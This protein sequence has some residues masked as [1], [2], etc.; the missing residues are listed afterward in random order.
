MRSFRAA[1]VAFVAAAAVAVVAAPLAT[2]DAAGLT[3]PVIDVH[4][5]INKGVSLSPNGDRSKDRASIKFTLAKKS[6]VIVRV[7][8]HNRARTVVYKK[9]LGTLSRGDHTWEW[10]GKNLNGNVVRDG[11]YSAVF[12]A[13]Q[14]AQ[15]GK[16]GRRSAGVF[17]DTDFN[18]Q[19][20]PKLS[21]DIVYP[22]TTV[23]H[24]EIGVTLDND[25]YDPMTAL[26]NVVSTLK[27]AQG[28]VVW[29][30]RPF[31]Y[32]ASE[33]PAVM[34]LS[35][36]GLDPKNQHP[37]PAGTYRLRYKVWDMAGNR[38]GSK[39]VTVHVSG[40]PLIES[41]GS[42]VVPPTG[43]S[44]AS[45]LAADT[46]ATTKPTGVRDGRSSTSGGND[47]QPVPCG[48]VVPSEVY[49]E[50]GAMSFRSSDTCGGTWRARAWRR[51]AAAS[52]W[53]R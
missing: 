11:R 37:L 16:T 15:A 21:A 19:W 23:I 53:T 10:N 27:D 49:T 9:R 29:T 8:R 36:S 22:H 38:G 2:A 43:G 28:R 35:F 24:D 31:D 5:D 25:R 17:V 50:P 13:D 48:T 1:A 42:I 4:V 3:R 52:P 51:P 30:S 46:S 40:K 6:D 14:V 44:K 47:T 12:V 26:G 33:Y 20:A 32:H 34:P 41:T 18:A 39:A 45:E 7:R